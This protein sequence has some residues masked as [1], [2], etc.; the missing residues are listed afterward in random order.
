M[1]RAAFGLVLGLTLTAPTF[2]GQG[3]K[4]PKKPAL[5]L[6]VVPRMAFSPV[7]AFFTAELTGGDDVEDLYCPEVLWEWGDGGKSI[8]EADCDPFEPGKT[9][10]QRRFTAEHEYK[11][12]GS[13]FVKV[14]LRRSEH[15]VAVAS[16]QL[17][18]RPGLGDRS[19]DP[20][21]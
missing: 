21:S 4:K 17:T 9:K 15:V 6:R 3:P 5:E 1:T 13:Y 12:A 8:Q 18:V 20:G 11:R 7:N 2:A 10:I 16:V 14:S 19:E